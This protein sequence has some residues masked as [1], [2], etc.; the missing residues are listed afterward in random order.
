MK[1]TLA[2][3]EQWAIDEVQ[4][5]VD[6]IFEIDPQI[7]EEMVNELMTMTHKLSWQ[8]IETNANPGRCPWCAKRILCIDSEPIDRHIEYEHLGL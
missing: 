2:Q 3:V 8:L 6:G 4:D 5:L 7:S 1:V